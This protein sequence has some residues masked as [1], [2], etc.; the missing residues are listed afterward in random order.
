MNTVPADAAT[1]L[2]NL[3]DAPGMVRA[4][5]IFDGISAHLAR[6]AGFEVAYLTGAGAVASGY[7][8][9][10]IGLAT[11]TEMA[12]RAALVVE[13]SGLPVV[14]DADTGYGNPM[15]VVRTVR[16]Y[17][18]AGV[19]AVQLEDQDFPKRCGHLDDKSVVATDDFVRKLV[20][21]LEA[22]Q[23]DTIVIARTDARG[24]LGLDEALARAS[25]YA[26]E[27]ADM[28]F[29][30]APTSVAEIERVAAEVTAPLV[31]NVVPSGRTPAI[32][33][34]DL[35]QLGYR[36]AIYPGALLQPATLAMASALVELGGDDP[37]VAHGPAG[38]FRTVGLDD[39][40]AL[41]EHYR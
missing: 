39:W 2:R 15:H 6:R 38:I 30:E 29:V 22:R 37:H 28:V 18:R 41:G 11:A 9:P 26:A 16:A 24:P 8:L 21:A 13:A 12:D 1:Q 14:A 7:G 27:G 23:N 17:E 34:A 5:G 3:L 36:M 25:R 33:D 40:A 20:A 35:E 32:P 10:D 4:P 31:F 19:A